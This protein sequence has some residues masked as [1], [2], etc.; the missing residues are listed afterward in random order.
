MAISSLNK[1]GLDVYNGVNVNFNNTSGEEAIR[2]MIIDAEGGK[3]DYYSFQQNKYKVFEIVSELLVL[4]IGETLEGAFN[5]VVDFETIGHGEQK[6]VNVDNNELFKVAY[7]ASGNAD[8]RR[9]RIYDKKITVE[10]KNLEIKLY[11]DLDRFLAGKISW[12]NLIDRVRRSLSVETAGR[13]HQAITTAYGSAITNGD[14]TKKGTFSE[15]TLDELIDRVE[16]RTGMK[17][18]IYGCKSGLGK[19]SAG[20]SAVVAPS[21]QAKDDY[22]NMGYFRNYKGTPMI[23]LPHVLTPGTNNFANDGNVLYILPA[24]QKLVKVVYEGSPIIRDNTATSE[25]NDMQLEY[26]LLQKM[27]VVCLLSGLFGLYELQ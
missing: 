12:T 24:G 26:L 2:N 22:N 8:I 14:Y 3:H 25:R 6:I 7:V 18:A 19:I 20:T 27:G 10:T 21:D 15:A 5:G 23:E 16:A 4:P 17:C 1:L 9:Q 13:I 11:D